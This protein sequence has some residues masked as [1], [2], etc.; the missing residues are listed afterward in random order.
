MDKYILV[1]WPESQEIMDHPRFSECLLVQ[2]IDGHIEV[3][4]S[5]Y[6][7][8]EDLYHEMSKEKS[9]EKRKKK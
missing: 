2:D 3:G 1:Q 9:K 8:P 6:M 5:A 4:S 7:V